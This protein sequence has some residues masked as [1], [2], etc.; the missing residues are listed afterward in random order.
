M[1]KF[2][3]LIR[4]KRKEQE[5]L[6]RHLS[7]ELDIDTG[8]MSKIERGER[9]AKREHVAKLIKIFK[10]NKGDATARWLS[11]QVLALLVNEAE[12]MKALMIAKKE[13]T[14]LNSKNEKNE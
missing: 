8:Q 5:M 13:I 1:D 4:S 11:D 12:A 3:A 7:A 14:Y 10:L 9:V 2:G 6:I